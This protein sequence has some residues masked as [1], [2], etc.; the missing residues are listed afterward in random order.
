MSSKYI[1]TSACMQ[2]IGDIFMNPSLLDLEDKYKF[3]E[4]DFP[5]E[6]HRVLFG[7]M[8]NLHQL[9][10]KQPSIEDI[11]KYLEQRPKKYAIYKTNKGSEYLENLKEMCQLAAFDY[12]Y[13]RMTKMTLLRMYNKKVG[14]DLSWLYDPDNI[15]DIKKK[16]KQETWFDNAPINEIANI[17]NDKIDEIKSKYVDNSED[18]VIQA[19]DGALNLLERLKTNPEIGY[20][21]Y[22][23]LVNA[24]HRGA[25]LKKFYLRS[26]ATGIGKSR[27]MIADACFIACNKIYNTETK[28]W[29][30]NGTR[31][32]TQFITTEQE[33]DEIQ[34]MMIAFLSGVNEDHILEN[35]YVGDEWER[36]IEAAKILSKSPLYIK[37]L[38]DFSLQD[39]ENTIKFGIRQYGIRYIFMDYIHSSMKILSEISSKAGVKGLRED[40]ILFMIGVRLKDLCNQY[41]VF[42]MSATQLNASYQTAQVYDQNLLRGAKSL[43]DK[44]DCGMIMLQVSQDDREALKEITNSMGIEMPDIKIS[45]Y[46]NR[47]GRYKD[48]LLWCKSNR[49]ICR[50]DPIF[51]TNYNY[52]LISIEDLKIKVTPKI[53]SSAF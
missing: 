1:D 5:T 11:E 7:S 39:I 25:R 42:I 31:E 45:V 41:G 20:P 30:E 19:G 49:G 6:F 34:T 16:E 22:G 2:V 44:I 4:E 35:T 50:I 27:S 23:K 53:E 13:N 9:G 51:V 8:Y 47:R 21:L 3:N 33:E 12:Y 40:N 15:F 28:E 24:I 36:V 52:E 48:I 46:K 43:G 17:I 37:K 14:I 26:A 38:P 29:E 32:P 18:G 10:A